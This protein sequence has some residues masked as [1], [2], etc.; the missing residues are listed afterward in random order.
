MWHV[1][2]LYI[3]IGSHGKFIYELVKPKMRGQFLIASIAQLV[4][5]RTCNA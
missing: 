4:E 5:Q 3:L 2:T 1:V